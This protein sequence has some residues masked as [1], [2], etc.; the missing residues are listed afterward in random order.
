[1]QIKV[2]ISRSRYYR[3]HA[4]SQAPGENSN[5]IA[6]VIVYLSDVPRGGETRFTETV[7]VTDVAPVAGKAVIFFPA[8]LPS[9]PT[10]PGGL[11]ARVEHEARPVIEGVKWIAQQWVW[12]HPYRGYSHE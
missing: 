6:T 9:A 7:P 12:S 2:V 1:M 8:R 3:K 10:D 5:R 4:E 11:A